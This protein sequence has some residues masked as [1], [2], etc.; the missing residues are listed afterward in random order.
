[1]DDLTGKCACLSLNTK[2]SQMVTLALDVEN[3]SKVL[4][5]K[6]FTKRK[7][8]VEALSRTLKSMWCSVQDFEIR[9]LNSNSVLIIFSEEANT[10]NPLP[11]TLVIR[12][13]SD[14]SI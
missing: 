12:Q 14:S 13:I 8:N 6:L 10:Q 3:N 5:A 9:F 4:V 7:V 1:M 2:E 11:A